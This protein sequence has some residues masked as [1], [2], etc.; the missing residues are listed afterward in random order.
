MAS[1]KQ[2]IG[3]AKTIAVSSSGFSD[4][5][6][7]TASLYGIEIR[8][9][10]ELSPE[11]I[12][13]WLKLGSVVHIVRHST[14]KKYDANLWAEAG[15]KSSLTLAAGVIQAFEEDLV[16]APVFK[17]RGN[18]KTLTVNDL[19]RAA[20]QQKPDVYEGVPEDG[21]KVRRNIRIELPK[22][23]IY[24]ETTE[25]PRGVKTLLL[26]FDL[27]VERVETPAIMAEAYAYSDAGGPIVQATEYLTS[28]LGQD[29]QIT[30]QSEVGSNEVHVTI[31]ASDVDAV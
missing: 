27:F 31:Q 3:A 26:G 19:W 18:S 15:D 16:N 10:E 21:T 12:L 13:G 9:I 8:R 7:K 20:Q 23:L 4:P 28:F 24:V 6:I 11:E 1:K 25:G 22:G 14:L 17:T 30:M 5:A 29:L 2:K